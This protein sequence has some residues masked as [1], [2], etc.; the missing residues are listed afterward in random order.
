MCHAAGPRP[1]CRERSPGAVAEKSWRTSSNQQPSC[2]VARVRSS[3]CARST[4]STTAAPATP[5]LRWPTAAIRMAGSPGFGPVA[6]RASMTLENGSRSTWMSRRRHTPE[7]VVRKLREADRLLGEGMEL[8]E[9]WKQ[10]E[11]SEATYHR[12]RTQ[13]GGM[14]ADDVK[15]LEGVGGREREAQA[16]R[17]R[18]GARGRGAEGDRAG[19]LVSPSRRR[20]AVWMLQDRLGISE[21]RACRYVGQPRSTQRRAPPVAQDDAA[22]RAQLRA[23]SR[24]R[25]RWGYRQAHQHLLEQGWAINRKRTQRLWR[26]EGLRVPAEAPQTPAPRGIDGAG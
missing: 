10:L 12:W 13:F 1:F 11:V 7:Q 23:F 6:M 19:K 20:R 21:R 22:L 17:R 24:Q 15:R 5:S 16:D 25:P 9:V 14:K 3:Q 18:P 2:S 8:P 26:E 4:A